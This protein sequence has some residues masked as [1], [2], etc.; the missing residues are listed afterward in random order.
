MK[1][2]LPIVGTIIVAVIG[3]VSHIWASKMKPDSNVSAAIVLEGIAN[4]SVNGVKCTGATSTCISVKWANH[5]DIN[6]VEKH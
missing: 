6:D 3:G 2:I 5:L 4:S 1:A